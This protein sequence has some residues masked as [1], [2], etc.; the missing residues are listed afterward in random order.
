MNA[1]THAKIVLVGPTNTGKTSRVREAM[2]TPPSPTSPVSPTLGVEVHVLTINGTSYNV[3][4]CAGWDGPFA[5]LR[6]T[7]VIGA[8]Y[9]VFVGANANTY[10]VTQYSQVA[11]NATIVHLAIGSP[12][13]MIFPVTNNASTSS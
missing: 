8:D 5:G 12:L 9:L 2:G 1:G 11:H 10:E 6:D 4:D 7:Y 13:S 3:W